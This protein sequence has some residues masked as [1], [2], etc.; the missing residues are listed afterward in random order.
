[1][2]RSVEDG[3]FFEVFIRDNFSFVKHSSVTWASFATE[4]K[5]SV[6]VP[7][8]QASLAFSDG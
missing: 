5:I 4:Q 1:M 2:R 8:A 6:L 3:K 7:E